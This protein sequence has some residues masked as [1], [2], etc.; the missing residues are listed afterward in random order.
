MPIDAE[1]TKKILKNY[2]RGQEPVSGRPADY[3]E[4]EIEAAKKAIGDLARSDED[5]LAYILYPVTM[6]K[7]LQEKYGTEPPKETGAENSHKKGV[8]A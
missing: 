8:A 4:P 3:L 5:V 1:L 2:K 6:T 7:F